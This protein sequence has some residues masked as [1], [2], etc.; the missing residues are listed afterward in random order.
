MPEP[1][2]DSFQQ[3]PGPLFFTLLGEE[4]GIAGGGPQ[5]EG[6]GILAL[7]DPDG[8]FIR[9]PLASPG[10]GS[11]SR[12]DWQVSPDPEQFGLPP[13]IPLGVDQALA[14]VLQ[15]QAFVCASNR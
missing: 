12:S 3:L 15:A 6:L 5:V 8:I 7:G 11:A 4:P 14:I 9:R 13:A 1:A 10:A 2:E